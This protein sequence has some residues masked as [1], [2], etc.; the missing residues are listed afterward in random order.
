MKK[1]MKNNMKYTFLIGMILLVFSACKKEYQTYKGKTVVEFAPAIKSRSQG[2]IAKPGYD[3]VK[4][5]L[6]GPQQSS[7]L[8]LSYSIDAASTAVSGTHYNIPNLGSFVL[9]ANSSFGYI[10]VN[11]VPGSIPTNA[12]S[13]QKTLILNLAGN[14]EVPASGMES[15]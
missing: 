3:S 2:T 5:Q 10:R 15:A 8:S 4:V 13:N 7:D 14:A 1:E 12:A 11:L 6:V 9:P